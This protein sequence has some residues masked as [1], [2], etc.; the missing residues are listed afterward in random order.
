MNRRGFFSNLFNRR[1]E[2]DP[3]FF[4]I[5]CV[6]NVYGEDTLRAQ[7]YRVINEQMP[8]ESPGEKFMFYKRITAVLR[9]NIHFFEYGYWDYVTDADDA[10][11]EFDDWVAGIEATAATVQEELGSEVD[12]AYRMSSEKD[13]VVVTLAFILEYTDSLTQFMEMIEGISEEEYFTPSGFQTLI[14][15]V[16]YIDFEYSIGDAVFIMPGNDQDGFSWSDMRSEG[17]DYLKPIMGTIGL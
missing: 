1:R 8:T 5:Q 4:G 17:W 7:L 6:I 15:S 9:E 16:N 2:G 11:A 3:L 13:Y 10:T 14:E 12:E